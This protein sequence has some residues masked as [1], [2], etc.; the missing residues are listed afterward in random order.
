MT[1]TGLDGRLAAEVMKSRSLEKELGEVKATL[2]MESNEHDA[3][4]VAVQLVYDDLKLASM[5]ETRSLTV[6]AV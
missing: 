4:H 2:L 6:H 5:Q 1:W 3:L